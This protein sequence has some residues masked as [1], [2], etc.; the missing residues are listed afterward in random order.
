MARKPKSYCV[1]RFSLRTFLIV[2][3]MTSFG[4]GWL[5]QNFRVYQ[6]EQ[7]WLK[8]QADEADASQPLRGW[9]RDGDTYSYYTGMPFI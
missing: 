8:K 3:V 9:T 6:S 2:C 1:P 5:A 7:S 4:I